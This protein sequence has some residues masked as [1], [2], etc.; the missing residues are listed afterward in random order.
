MSTTNISLKATTNEIVRV[1]NALIE[2][3]TDGEK[4]YALAAADVRDAA[5]KSA[6]TALSKQRADFVFA[7]QEAVQ[8]LGRFP[9]NEGTLKG[10]LHQ[11]WTFARLAFEGRS[12]RI[13]LE[14]CIRG[15]QAAKANYDAALRRVPLISLPEEMRPM[16]Q[17]Q[18]AAVSEAFQDLEKS[19]SAHRAS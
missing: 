8:E 4:G 9:E 7:L 11:R 12:D 15:E 18:A 17:H 14:E 3:C 2:T 16:L 1:L 6:F 10:Q 13:V 5:L 19:L